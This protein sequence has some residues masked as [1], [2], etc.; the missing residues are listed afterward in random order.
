MPKDINSNASTTVRVNP[1]ENERGSSTRGGNNAVEVEQ[2]GNRGGTSRVTDRSTSRVTDRSSSDSSR[3]YNQRQ[4]SYQGQVDEQARREAEAAAAAARKAKE[5]ENKRRQDEYNRRKAAAQ[6]S[7]D[8]DAEAA[9]IASG[10]KPTNRVAEDAAKPQQSNETAK[11]HVSRILRE[12]SVNSPGQAVAAE[13]SSQAVDQQSSDNQLSEQPRPTDID[14]MVR[15]EVLADEQ[16]R[17]TRRDERQ[18]QNRDNTKR[19]DNIAR[20]EVIN[21]NAHRSANAVRE[22]GAGIQPREPVT[23]ETIDNRLPKVEIA[24]RIPTPRMST[25]EF[26]RNYVD[27]TNQM[28]EEEAQANG[29]HTE[30][31][32]YAQQVT[33]EAPPLYDEDVLWNQGYDV[34]G[35]KHRKWNRIVEGEEAKRTKGRYLETKESRGDISFDAAEPETTFLSKLRKARNQMRMRYFN[36]SLVHIDGEKLE[37]YTQKIDGKEHTYVRRVYS[38]RIQYAINE[39]QNIYDCSISDVMR[40]IQLRAGLGIDVNG[41]IATVDPNEFKLTEDQAYELMR[42]IRD[43]QRKN[44]H[45]LGPVDGKPGGS[46]VRDDTG[47]FVVVGGTRCFSLGYMPKDLVRS[48]SRN[49]GSALH[50]LTE[51]QIQ[52]MIADTWINETY[53]QLCANT[54]GNLMYQARAIENMVRAMASIDGTDPSDLGIPKVVQ[55][56]TLMEM[57]AEQASIEDESIRQANEVKH[58]RTMSALSEWSNRYWKTNGT[59]NSDGSIG[60]NSKRRYNKGGDAFRTLSNLER[61]AKAANIMIMISSVP[62]AVI[63]RKEQSLANWLSEAAFRSM[64]EDVANGYTVTD[65]LS[66]AASSKE[67]IDA[68]TV[69]ES[70]YRIGGHTAIDA[71]FTEMS[72]DGRYMNRLTKADLRSFLQRWGVTGNSIT[73]ELREKLNLKTPGDVAGFLSNVSAVLDGAMLGS[74]MFRDG[75]SQQFVRMSM[76]E[77]ARAS[78]HGRESYTNAQVEQWASRG[79]EEMIRSLL[80]TDAGREAFMTQGITSLGRKSPV[81]HMMRRVMSA[82]G[83]TEF[84]IRSM[85][86]RFPEYGVNKVLEMMP[87]S[88]TISF[89]ASRGISS[90][91]DIL[92]QAG[93]ETPSNVV[94]NAA[95]SVGNTMSRFRDYQAGG[96]LSFGEG[97]RKNLMYDCVM[98]GEKILIAGI[99][100]AV[101]AALGGLQPPDDDRDRYNWSEWKIGSG[102]DAIPIKWAWWMDDLSGI[103]LPLGMAWAICEQGGW[104]DEAKSTATNTF[105]NAVANL[106]SGTAVFDFIDLVNNFEQEVDAALDTQGSYEPS[107][108]EWLMTAIEQGAWDLVGDLTPTYISQVCPWSKDFLFRGGDQDAHTASKVYNTSRKSKSEAEA[109]QTTER[110]GSYS[111]YVRRRA[112]QTNVLYAMFMDWITG[113]SDDE[114][115]LTGYKYTEQ[116]LDTMVDPYAQKMFDRFFL[117]LD[118]AT[119]DIAPGLPEDKREALLDQKAEDVVQWIDDHYT[120]ATQAALDGFVLNYDARVNCINYCHKMINKAWENYYSSLNNGWLDDDDYQAVLQTRKDAIDHYNNLIYNYFQSDEIGWSLPRYVRQESDRETRYVDSQGNPMT[121]L[122]TL[123]TSIQHI[124]DNVMNPLMRSLELGDRSTTG[125]RATKESYWYGN[126]N[127][128]LP[129]YSPIEEGKGRNYETIPYNIVLDENGNPVNDVGAMYDNAATMDAISMGRLEGKDVQE[130]MWGG[131][132]N[133][134]KDDVSEELAIP[135]EGVPTLG[136][137]GGSGG[138]RPWRLLESSVPEELGLGS[139]DADAVS[140]RLGIPSSLPTNGKY[141]A[142]SAHDAEQSSGGGGG[143]G[144][145]GG[146]NYYGGGGGGSY[147]YSGGGGGGYSSSYNPRIYSNAR[148]VNSDRASG[149]RSNTPYKATSTYLRPGFYTKGSREAYKRSDL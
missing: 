99:Y 2:R 103:G 75:E 70:L 95:E 53:P 149:M 84:A 23:R 32:E 91:G 47:K 43:S 139:L 7:L 121:Y 81:E 100:A 106:N 6:K 108:D 18:S 41:T 111:D 147:Y 138:G 119:T 24:D 131:Q 114:S 12:E 4:S 132:G 26:Y 31:R 49:W 117:D 133:N 54:G 137:S 44:G 148:Q 64:H 83:L 141:A 135:R 37:S 130:L 61:A 143:N 1:R 78:V 80:Q 112:T 50:G 51:R 126:R 109:D 36:P 58:S 30:S 110:T 129:F 118:P 73:D 60:S 59:R 11:E 33:D 72:D 88:N 92:A 140:E 123:P 27:S 76:A 20:Q 19:I 94:S 120:N 125:N 93:H 9:L 57:R 56:K 128:V 5:D 122:D 85:F 71:F 127:N 145:R 79:G 46:G 90:V 52:K 82:N 107:R 10:L 101:I 144:Y 22:Q 69:A 136:G 134:L 39:I 29:V 102:D 87:M 45:P 63:A 17:R 62:E 77:M 146:Y 68:L 35:K 96:R 67:A 66:Q 40:L 3:S 89:L 142:Q 97:F 42:D 55:N 115:D 48:L 116:P 14:Q 28:L 15:E 13:D 16:R 124:A 21:D 105:I 104:S 74:G 98:G 25:G 86:D 38:E 8:L 65:R 113:A 34:T